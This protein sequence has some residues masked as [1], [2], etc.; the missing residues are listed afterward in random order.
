MHNHET[1]S[2]TDLLEELYRLDPTLRHYEGD[3]PQILATLATNRPGVV[4]EKAFIDDLRRSLLAKA[5]SPAVT[6]STTQLIPS[7]FFWWTARLAP[8][9]IAVLVLIVLNQERLIIPITPA[10]IQEED[11]AAIEQNFVMTVDEPVLGKIG[12]PDESH[13]SVDAPVELMTTTESTA[14]IQMTPSNLAVE[15]PLTDTASV[16]ITSMTLPEAG[17]VV[18]HVD[19]GGNLGDVLGSI[20]QVAGTYEDILLPLTRSL[21]YPELITVVIYTGQYTE[22]FQIEAETIQRD[23]LTTAPL[24]ITVPVISVLEQELAP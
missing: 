21:Q 12:T 13:E 9:G 10:M 19:A 18:M 16:T 24:M 7:S 1:A 17:W 23:P 5:A 6:K 8:V 14:E 22:T 2:Q 20:Y 11:T 15:P 3:I 4:V